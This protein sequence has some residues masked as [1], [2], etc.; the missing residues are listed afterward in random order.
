LIGRTASSRDPEG[1]ESVW[2]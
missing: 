1:S 2:L